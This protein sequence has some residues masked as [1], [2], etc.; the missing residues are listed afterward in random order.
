MLLA[1]PFP[2]RALAFIAAFLPWA[3]PADPSEIG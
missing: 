2:G 1:C 3:Y